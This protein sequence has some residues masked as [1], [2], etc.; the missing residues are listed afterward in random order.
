MNDPSCDFNIG[1]IKSPGAIL[2][3]ASAGLKKKVA[4]NKALLAECSFENT[5]IAVENYMTAKV[6]AVAF[7]V[8]FMF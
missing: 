6:R 5:S 3:T 8:G 4:S 7:R 1:M 2:V